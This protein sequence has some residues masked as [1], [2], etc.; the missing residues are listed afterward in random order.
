MAGN[1]STL[2]ALIQRHIVPEIA[3]NFYEG[4]PYF[5][6]LEQ[7]GRYVEKD[8][9]FS[10]PILASDAGDD[11]A[12]YD[13][14]DDVSPATGGEIVTDTD[15]TL[16]HFKRS[17]V[18]PWTEFLKGG[19]PASV[20]ELLSMYKENAQISLVDGLADQLWTDQDASATTLLG[21]PR[22]YS[23]TTSNACGGLSQDNQSVWAPQRVAASG[24]SNTLA[25]ADIENAVISA[26]FGMD[27]PD[28]ALMARPAYKK[29]LALFTSNERFNEHE[30]LKVGFKSIE[31][32]G[33]PHYVD[34]KAPKDTSSTG[35]VIV[36][37][38]SRWIR[39]AYHPMDWFS[40]REIGDNWINQ[41]VVGAQYFVS[42]QHVIINRR[43]VAVI[44]TFT[45][46]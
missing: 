43:S 4:H 37:L 18:I 46:S 7:K 5:W 42:L 38:N 27:G 30:G 31:V 9:D 1:R 8:Q 10:Y 17:V 21:I 40:S 39:M 25:R 29:V 34:A 28:I 36:Y 19:G 23:G 41:R 12:G 14:L 35:N 6:F 32:M 13:G 3:D 44:H 22:M 45:A 26:T 11:F 24:A 20:K 16:A 15:Y 2:S 33:I